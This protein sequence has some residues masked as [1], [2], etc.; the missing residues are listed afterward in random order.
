LRVSLHLSG[1]GRIT[2]L[3]EYD[4]S[5]WKSI[6]GFAKIII[7]LQT[8]VILFLSF[9]IYQEYLNNSYLQAYLTGNL[10]G[11]S[12]TGIVLI[13]IGL[14]TIVAIAL[15][16]R[17][18]STRKELEGITSSETFRTGGRGRGQPVDTRTEQHLIEMIRKTMP[19]MDSRPKTDGPMPTLSRKDSQSRPEE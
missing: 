5:L 15:Y 2:S 11:I 12:F 8:V 16:A 13:S 6:P 3:E 7:L 10:Q 9:W 19:I 4:V 14:F 17:L 18:R 1:S